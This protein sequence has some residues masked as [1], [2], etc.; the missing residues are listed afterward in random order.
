MLTSLEH[1]SLC[2]AIY[3]LN[4]APLGYADDV[5]S[6]IAP[7]SIIQIKSFNWYMTIA[8]CRDI[9]S[10]LKRVQSLFLEKTNGRIETTRNFVL[11]DM[12]THQSKKHTAMII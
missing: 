8:V 5:V 2:S 10:T 4:V 9:D 11:I 1:S 7:V 3:G 6:A 12:D